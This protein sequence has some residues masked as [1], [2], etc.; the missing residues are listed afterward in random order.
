MVEAEVDKIIF[1]STHAE[2]GYMEAVGFNSSD[3]GIG[4]RVVYLGST[5]FISTRHKGSTE[6]QGLGGWC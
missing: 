4:G 2:F 1:P 3:K 6:K 5:G